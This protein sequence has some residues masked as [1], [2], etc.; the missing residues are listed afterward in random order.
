MTG[1][2][3]K[4]GGIREGSGRKQKYGEPTELMR[5][6]LSLVPKFKKD[7]EKAL[8]KANKKKQ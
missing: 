1:I 4:S 7:L 8:K 6:P 2:K 5:V 3:G